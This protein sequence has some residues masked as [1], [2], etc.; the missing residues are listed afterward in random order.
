[1]CVCVRE[2]EGETEKE[3]ERV[4]RSVF[5]FFGRERAIITFGRKYHCENETW[6]KVQ[7]GIF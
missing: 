2:K 6:K 4:G 5:F 7:E 3:R 1:M